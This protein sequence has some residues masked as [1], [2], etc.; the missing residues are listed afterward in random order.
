[1]K[2][3]LCFLLLSVH[4]GVL[5]R[6]SNYILGNTYGYKSSKSKNDIW[7]GPKQD[8]TCYKVKFLSPP[9]SYLN[10]HGHESVNIIKYLPIQDRLT[11]N[12]K[13]K[14]C[15]LKVERHFKNFLIMPMAHK[16]Y[17]LILVV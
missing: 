6:S 2:F 1:M 14:H 11:V 16:H 12:L 15:S 3:V 13:K 7:E 4:C 10:W 17:C 8:D 5:A 9:S